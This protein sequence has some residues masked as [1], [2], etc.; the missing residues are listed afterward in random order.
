M[1]VANQSNPLPV[2]RSRGLA[3]YKASHR[4]LVSDIKEA[5]FYSSRLAFFS[6]LDYSFFPHGD[7][8]ILGLEKEGGESSSSGGTPS[9]FYSINIECSL[10]R[11]LFWSSVSSV[12]AC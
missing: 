10:V 4:H 5:L 9:L 8:L 11:S 6:C 3:F 2:G 12:R 7:F 1:E